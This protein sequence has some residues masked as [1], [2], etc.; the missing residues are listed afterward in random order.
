MRTQGISSAL[1]DILRVSCLSIPL[2]TLGGCGPAENGGNGSVG[3]GGETAVMLFSANDG[4]TGHELWKTDGTPEGTVLVKDINPSAGSSPSAGVAL[5]G[6]IYFN[7]NDG[8]HGNELWRTDGTAAGTVLV[9]DINPGAADSS[10]R[11]AT[12]YNGAL[13]FQADDGVRGNELWKTDGTANG[14]VLVKDINPA[15]VAS[16]FSDFIFYND[17]LFFI[18]QGRLWKTDGSADGTVL[19]KDIGAGSITSFNGYLYFGAFDANGDGGLWKTDGTEAGTVLVRLL[20]PVAG[21]GVTPVTPRPGKLV[22]ANGLLFFRAGNSVYENHSVLWKSDGS[23]EGTTELRKFLPP[24]VGRQVPVYLIAINGE[25]YFN[26]NDGVNGYEVW[27]SDGTLEGTTMVKDIHP[28]SSVEMIPSYPYGPDGFTVF[29]DA[30]YFNG[31]DG[32]NGTELWK[33]DG[34]PEGTIMVKD[35]N[36][37]NDSRPGNYI[38]FNNTLYFQADDGVNGAELWKTNGTEAGTV[39]VKDINTAPGAGS[40]PTALAVLNGNP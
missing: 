16:K 9:K 13:Y 25:V 28:V 22:V 37:T 39:L 24:R 11:G 38:V 31:N 19:V 6:F 34:T 8:V 10:P 14:T 15:G 5:N 36:P 17:L 33:T 23:A 29:N 27:K 2:I 20:D 1:T 35:I 32:V 18:A 26:A 30:L 4:V 7:A 40:Y 3:S 21:G 12:Q